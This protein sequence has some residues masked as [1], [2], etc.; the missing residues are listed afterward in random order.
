[1]RG[2]SGRSKE[3]EGQDFPREKMYFS[4]FIATDDRQALRMSHEQ[5]RANLL[6]SKPSHRPSTVY[7]EIAFEI[8]FD[9][10]R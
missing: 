7:R 6:F 5:E 10:H 9:G 8:A 3:S 2:F 4:Q 1:L